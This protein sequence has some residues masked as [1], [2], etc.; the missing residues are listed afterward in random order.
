MVP[1]YL[2]SVEVALRDLFIRVARRPSEHLLRRARKVVG[3][4]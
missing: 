3:S 4:R 2:Q 1:T